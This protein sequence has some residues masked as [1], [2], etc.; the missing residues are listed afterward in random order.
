L[1]DS[2]VVYK[3]SLPCLQAQQ[4]LLA[5]QYYRHKQIRS[6]AGFEFTAVRQGPTQVNILNRNY[7]LHAQPVIQPTASKP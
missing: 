2:S 5:T 6:G 3:H 1:I 4:T 7:R